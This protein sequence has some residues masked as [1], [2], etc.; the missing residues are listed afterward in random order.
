MF[1][2]WED[3]N[4]DLK[5]PWKINFANKDQYWGHIKIDKK[6]WDNELLQ[7]QDFQMHN[8]GEMHYSK[9]N[10][11]Y[12]GSFKD[13]KRCGYG[14]CVFSNGDRYFGEWRDDLFHGY[15]TFAWKD[16]TLYQGRFIKGKKSKKGILFMPNG[17]TIDGTWKDDVI[18]NGTYKK[19]TTKQLSLYVIFYSK[20]DHVGLH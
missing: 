16:G 7:L 17:D 9:K 12:F 20:T 3:G 6:R 1:G 5:T 15:G 8:E 13:G 2:Q 4:P 18:V 10:D 11:K 14:V 19:G